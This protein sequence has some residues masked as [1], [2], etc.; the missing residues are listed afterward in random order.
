MRIVTLD[1][2]VMNSSL[3]IVASL[4]VGYLIGSIPFGYI[5]G[6]IRGVDVR[7]YGSGKTGATNVLRTLGVVAGVGVFT[8]DMGKG[9]AAT[10]LGYVFHDGSYLAAIGGAFAAILGHNF[11][12]Y[13]RF[14]GGRGVA[15]YFGSLVGL[16]WPLALGG[17]SVALLTIA[18]SRFV[19]LGSILGIVTTCIISIVMGMRGGLPWLIAVFT[20]IG[21]GFIVFQHRD[22]ISRLLAG[23]ERRLG[24]AGE[25]REPR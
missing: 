25:R 1:L 4:V 16:Y 11:P 13:L 10:W 22:N 6:K 5:V 2:Y 15:T 24:E 20:V 19:S 7:E 9:L 12:L 14:R 17:G 18:L 21:G 23:R 8:L 3:P